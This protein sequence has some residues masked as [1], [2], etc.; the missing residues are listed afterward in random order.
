MKIGDIVWIAHQDLDNDEDNIDCSG[1]ITSRS[2]AH[3]NGWWVQYKSNYGNFIETVF[4]ENEL[5]LEKE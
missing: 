5:S 1:I 3:Y 2:L 4:N